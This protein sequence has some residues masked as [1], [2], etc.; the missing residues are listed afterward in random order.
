MHAT[1]QRQRTIADAVGTMTRAALREID[2]HPSNVASGTDLVR[3]H[4]TSP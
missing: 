1:S 2:D 3:G 4:K